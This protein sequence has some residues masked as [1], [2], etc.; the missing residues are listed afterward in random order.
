M[1]K[2]GIF[3]GG[4]DSGNT[5]SVADKLATLLK[6]ASEDVINIADAGIDTLNKYDRLIF[7]TSSWGIGGAH[8]D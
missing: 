2:T 8:Y 6:V 3:Y 5:K 1:K 4:S 7:G